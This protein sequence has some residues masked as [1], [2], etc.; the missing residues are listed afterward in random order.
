M[1][2]SSVPQ[3]S[4]FHVSSARFGKDH[5]S[6]LAY[7]ETCCVDGKQGIGKVSAKRMRCNEHTHPLL[8]VSS[9]ES[10]WKQGYST[11][12]RG[13]FQFSGHEDPSKAI[14]GGVQLQDHDDWDCLDDLVSA[15]YVDILNPVKGELRMTVTGQIMAAQ[16]REHKARGGKFSD[17]SLQ[18]GV[19]A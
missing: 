14:A 8:G 19:S 12:L 6:L 3:L 5:W 10:S 9:M 13:F 18:Q 4:S 2:A 15:R 16:L 11:R 7:I 1:N 17:F